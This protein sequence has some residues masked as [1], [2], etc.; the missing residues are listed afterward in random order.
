MKPAARRE[1]PLDPQRS[2]ADAAYLK[3]IQGNVLNPHGRDFTRLVLFRFTASGSALREFFPAAVQAGFV[4]SAWQQ[5]RDA[6]DAEAAFLKR[7]GRA[8]LKK[9]RAIERTIP[10]IAMTEIYGAAPFYGL[11]FTQPGLARCG[12]APG[13]WPIDPQFGIPMSEPAEAHA[14][15]DPLEGGQPA[16]EPPY[17]AEPHGVWLLAHDDRAQLDVMQA[18]IEKFLAA[19]GA[20]PLA[21]ESGFRWKDVADD[22]LVREPFGFVDGLSVPEFFAGAAYRRTPDWIRIPRAQIVIA[23]NGDPRNDA[24]AGGS[25]MVLRKLAQDVRAFRA[26]EAEL[27][28]SYPAM[29]ANGVTSLPAD[30][31]ALFVGRERDG[32]PLADVRAN[33]RGPNDFSFN[34]DVA[35]CPFHAHIRKSNPR[36]V[37]GNGQDSADTL[38]AQLFVRRS[39]IYDR[40]GLL[41][42]RATPDYPQGAAIDA[43]SEVGLLFIGYMSALSQFGTMQKNW[44]GSPVFPMPGTSL[45]D[46][47]LRPRDVLAASGAPQPWAWSG[48]T[49]ALAPFVRPRGGAY[50]YVPSIPWLKA[51]RP[52]AA[53]G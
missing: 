24:H 25:F 51:Q 8:R 44:F 33:G 11:G 40:R 39:A 7:T 2:A 21:T 28:R 3:K 52:T 45:G 17:L 29:Q 1:R 13:D 27:R 9:S 20:Q 42:P 10:P 53:S 31:G 23:P 38:R 15:G 49:C 46:P 32:T 18:A 41:P 43:N 48:A 12:Y 37:G 14:L 19:H 16:W 50:F 5:W 35:R 36:M 6:R 22:S 30:P 4:T 26:T 34:H 47:L